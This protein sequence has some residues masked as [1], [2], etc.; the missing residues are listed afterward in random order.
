M[1]RLEADTEEAFV[2]YAEELGCEAKKLREDGVNGFPD[3]TI[4]TPRGSYFIEFKRTE[5]ETLR[6]EQ[7]K[8][9]KRLRE[10]GRVVLVTHCLETAKR[11]LDK[12][13]ER[14]SQF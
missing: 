14:S 2:K 10:L 13:L 6:P 4:L 3:R 12:W 5:K 7:R 11:S 8:Q 9:I 1:A